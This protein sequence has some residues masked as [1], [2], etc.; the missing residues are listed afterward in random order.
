MTRICFP[1][2]LFISL[3]SFA[4]GL[5]NTYGSFKAPPSHRSC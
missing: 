5:L 1:Y 2:I 4:S 3:V